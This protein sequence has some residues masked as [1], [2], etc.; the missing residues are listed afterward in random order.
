M[1][2]INILTSPY[3]T[4]LT[5]ATSQDLSEEDVSPTEDSYDVVPQTDH[6]IADDRRLEK[7]R[8]RL[9]DLIRPADLSDAEYSTFIRYCM[10]FFVDDG[11]LWRKDSQGT[12]KLV[13]SPETRF[14][15]MRIGH[16]QIG[17]KSFFATKAHIM[18][19]FLVAQ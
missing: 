12:H 19:H 9:Q 14:E 16:D 3:P 8:K 7:V 6:A 10:E 15:I 5:Y 4:I 13:A 1:H 2:Q 17:H 18:E 11:H